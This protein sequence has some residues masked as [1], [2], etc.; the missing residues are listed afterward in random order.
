M[1][2]LPGTELIFLA[3][4]EGL[5]SKFADDIELR[6]AVDTLEGRKVLQ[7]DLSNLENCAITNRVKFNKS[8]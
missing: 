8:K 6:V 1:L 5:L 3:V 7:R 2:V 4:A